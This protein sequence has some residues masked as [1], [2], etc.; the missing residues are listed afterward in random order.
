MIKSILVCTD[1]SPYGDTAC[2]YATYLASRLK[3]RLLGLHVLDS[4]MLEGP[5]MADISGWLGAQPYGAQLTQF[6][7]L[8]E[9]KGDA[10]LRAFSSRCDTAGVKAEGWVKMGHPIRVIVAEE[11]R[12]ELLIMGQKGEHADWIGDLMGSTV[13]R[14][15]RHSVKP[16]LVTPAAFRP[17]ARIM[18]AYDG[19]QHA[20]QAL[21]EATELAQALGVELI[22]LTVTNPEHADDTDQIVKDAKDLVAAHD[23]KALSL[24]VEGEP[25]AAILESAND[26]KCDLIVVGAYGHSRIREMILGSTTTQILTSSRVPVML[27]R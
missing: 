5:M 11:A 3:A 23:F 13:E 12:A 7:D 21:H 9:Q 16:C 22:V 1:G 6:R 4:R 2:E 15:V 26:E 24:V 18:A 27:V 17:I 25:A 14:V 19:S 8:M 10:I 20:S